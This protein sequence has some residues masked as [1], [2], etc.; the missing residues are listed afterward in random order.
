MFAAS[1]DALVDPFTTPYM[2]RA[3]LAVVLLGVAGGLFGAWIVLRRLAFFTHAV[4]TATFPGLV[5]AAPAGVPRPSRRWAPRSSSRRAGAAA[6]R[7]AAATPT[8]R[9]ACCS[10]R[11]WRSASILAGDV[12]ASGAGV[13]RLLFGT[14]LGLSDADLWLTARGRRAGAAVRPRCSRALAGDGLRPRRRTGAR[15][16]ARLADRLLLG[17]R[18]GRRRRRARR[19]RRAARHRRAR[20]PRRDRAARSA[21]SLRAL[22]LGDVALAAVEGAA[23]VCG[24]PMRSTSAPGPAI[25]VLG[26]AGL[27]RAGPRDGWPRERS[28]SVYG[29]RPAAMRP[30]RA[31][32]RAA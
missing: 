9:P 15:R 25:A 30:A 32:A 5:V 27:R 31:G 16:P 10:S 28:S 24:S 13:D 7:R 23:A 17:R 2:Q 12:F 21:R 14:L 11:R 26:G 3:L 4:G 6:A 19:G 29:A 18:G 20:R 1:V 8:P 22:L